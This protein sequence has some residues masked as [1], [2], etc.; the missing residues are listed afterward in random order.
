MVRV[1][2]VLKIL[3]PALV[4]GLG[5]AATIV[6]ITQARSGI[7]LITLFALTI[8]PVPLFF[9]RR[10][11]DNEHWYQSFPR[12]RL[13]GNFLAISIAVVGLSIPFILLHANEL[14]LLF[15]LL[16]LLGGILTIG[17]VTTFGAL[18]IRSE[19]YGGL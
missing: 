5:I 4:F 15:A 16:T 14:S 12:S 1:S 11:P 7:P 9:I 2:T 19:D 6:A 8:A 13:L 3:L 10:L 18:H 17:S